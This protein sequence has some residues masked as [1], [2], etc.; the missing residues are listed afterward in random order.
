MAGEMEV[1][2]SVA[3]R[4]HVLLRREMNRIVDV[5]WICM[6]ARYANEVIRLARVAHSDELHQLADRLHGLHPLLPHI[7]QPP[8]AL[9]EHPEVKYVA[10]LR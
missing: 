4:M 5:E 7:T 8:T 2:F 6:D 3:G 9:Q 10:T 1:V